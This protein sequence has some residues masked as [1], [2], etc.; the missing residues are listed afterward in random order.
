MTPRYRT[1]CTIAASTMGSP[2]NPLLDLP[3][4]RLLELAVLYGG[5]TFKIPT[6]EEVMEGWEV[7]RVMS[8]NQQLYELWLQ[9][10]R[11]EPVAPRDIFL[12]LRG[13]SRSISPEIGEKLSKVAAAVLLRAEDLQA[14]AELISVKQK[15]QRP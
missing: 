15:R 10:E 7:A 5:Q 2:A 4:K 8:E 6:I 9:K 11:G 14:A 3:I 13:I 1:T 12:A